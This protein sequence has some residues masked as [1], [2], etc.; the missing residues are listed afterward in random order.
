MRQELLAGTVALTFAIAGGAPAAAN[1]PSSGANTAPQAG[2]INPAALS[3]NNE[4]R[5]FNTD[6]VQLS[7]EE[8]QAIWQAAAD[9]NTQDLP[10]HV[11]AIPGAALPKSVSLKDIPSEIKDQ[12]GGDKLKDYKFAKFGTGVAIVDPS[13]N[14]VQAVITEHEASGAGQAANLDRQTTGQAA[15]ETDES[16]SARYGKV[17]GEKRDAGEDKYDDQPVKNE[18]AFNEGPATQQTTGA[19]AQGVGQARIELSKEQQQAIFEAGSRLTKQNLPKTAPPAAGVTVPE[20]I[21]L[22]PMPA[23]VAGNAGSGG[24]DRYS[25]LHV[26]DDVL[27]VDPDSR[28]VQAVITKKEVST[29]G[30]Q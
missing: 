27:V 18:T 29:V 8:D 20:S 13:N 9:M 3:G 16:I 22:T 25:L 7:A 21:E 14:T 12:V 15:N 1:D 2:E 11:I 24:L 19:G 6:R 30:Q 4:D 28:I 17:V 5:V 10:P 23:S 26:A